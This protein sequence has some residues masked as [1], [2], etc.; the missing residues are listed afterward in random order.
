MMLP[1]GREQMLRCWSRRRAA[2]HHIKFLPRICL[3]FCLLYSGKN[4]ASFY[5]FVAGGLTWAGTQ[6]KKGQELV[7]KTVFFFA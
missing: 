1:H 7:I 3:P 2:F 6:K 5:A 4:W